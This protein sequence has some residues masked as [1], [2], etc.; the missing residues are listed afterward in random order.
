MLKL[1][2]T[3]ITMFKEP[4]SAWLTSSIIGRAHTKGILSTSII[5]I[6]E[7]LSGD[8]HAADDTPYGGGPGELLK[9]DII[10]PLIKQALAKNS[11]ISRDKKRVVLMDPAGLPFDQAH[12]QRLAGYSELIFICG[13]Y[14]GIDA[15]IHYYID[16]ALS[17]GDF[18]LSG[19]DIAAMAMFDATARMVDGVLGNKH[20]ALDESHAQ[21][22]L[23]ASLYTRPQTYEGYEVP[24]VYKSGDH[25]KIEQA[26]RQESC[27][28]TQ[29]IR[30]DLVKLF[31]F[32][33][34]EKE[35][36]KI[37]ADL[38]P[39]YPWMKSHG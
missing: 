16:E 13:R 10:E 26:K 11:A 32:S 1:S 38:N 7:S 33:S 28:K 37:S 19:G 29:N 14:E 5:S 3:F 31:P 35:L 17:L 34:Y 36:L 25:K 6:L 39:K 27:L 20:S 18:V 22:R 30:P 15:R 21:G 9:I 4:L 2:A 24:L 8:H 23:E 12:A